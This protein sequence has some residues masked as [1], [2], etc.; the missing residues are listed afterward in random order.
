MER[1]IGYLPAAE[2]VLRGFILTVA[3][4][5]IFAV[6]MT[7][8]DVNE[9]VSSA[10]YLITTLVSIMYG[11]IYAVKKVKRRGWLIG[12]MVTIL[13]FLIIYL[14][15]VISGNSAVIGVNRIE[16]FSLGMIVGMLSGMLGINL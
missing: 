4:L 5:L 8:T 16:R 12:I 14:V 1:D 2:G 10:F 15:S 9:K 3:L 11:S 7:F 6:I 13:Y